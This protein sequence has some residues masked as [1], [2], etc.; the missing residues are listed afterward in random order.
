MS[1]ILIWLVRGY[2]I[3][4]SPWIGQSCRFNPTCSSYAIDALRE[5]GALRGSWMAIRRIGRC[6]PWNEG[7]NDPV[8]PKHHHKHH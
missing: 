1:K 8:P 2:Q 3:I 5:Y 7:G 6:H 4:L